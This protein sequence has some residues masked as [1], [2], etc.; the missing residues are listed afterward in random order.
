[1]TRP[2]KSLTAPANPP[3]ARPATAAPSL[4][5]VDVKVMADGLERLGYDVEALLAAAGFRRTDLGDPDRRVPCELVGQMIGQAQA[6]RFT[7]NLALALAQE[8]PLGAFPLLDYL[9]V[10]TDTVG[11]GLQQL[12]RYLRVIGS[13]GSVAVHADVDPVR[14]ETPAA[15]PFAVEYQMAVIARHMRAETEGAFAVTAM[16]VRHRLDDPAGYA[17]A[18]GC[19]IRME[20]TW[21]GMTLR[22]EVLALPMR[23]RDPLLREF[24]ERQADDVIARLPA[25][26]GLAHDVHRVL[27]GTVAA[28]G[29]RMA[30]LAREL[31]MSERTLQ[32]RL[33]RE[34]VSYQDLVDDVRKD[35]A[36]R[37]LGGSP[38][39]IGE[40]AYLLGYSE[41]AA[42]HRAFK[43]WYSVTP[44]RFRASHRS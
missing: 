14:V 31:G 43:R 11:D 4:P 7:P 35:A 29:A 19:A 5:S 12:A 17:S 26:T 30:T 8:T 1:M 6:V 39:A 2:A 41:P 15:W 28:G 10:S 36:A 42:F 21:D 25:R 38:L 24:L 27:A 3:P 16:H 34:G 40:I 33:A 23:R 22:R 32:R 44:E 37:Y 9:I 20:D 18:F 13:P